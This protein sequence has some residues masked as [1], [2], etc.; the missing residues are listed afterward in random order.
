MSE[1][2]SER[3][4][5]RTGDG[6]AVVAHR[7]DATGP[8]AAVVI[9]PALGV[10]QDFYRDFAAWL[11]QRGFTALTFDYRGIGHSAPRSLRRF[12][13][14]IDDWIRFDFE[15]A[16]AHAR[17]RCDGL[18]L[19]VVGH[20]LGAQLVALTPSAHDV[21]ALVAVAGGSGYW[22]GF[23]AR[24]RVLMLLML[25]GAAPLSI[26]LAGY[27]PGR[28]LRILGD[29]PAG[30]MRQWRRW[31]L[32]E[33]YLVGVEPGAREAYARARFDVLSLTFADDAMMPLR[34]V[35]TLHAHLRG[36]QREA[37]RIT[38]VEAGGP[39]GHLGFFRGRHRDSLW[40][41]AAEWLG[42]RAGMPA[43]SRGNGIRGFVL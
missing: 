1:A 42:A 5:L 13:A 25:H 29:L 4:A 34:N 43:T 15:A 9:A 7:F 6:T 22:R 19:F 3:V 18:P 40:P 14:T 24:M 33:E 31:C 8:R 36:V 10:R 32:N 26:P 41:I 27:F 30:V 21:R 28:R 20:S 37:R 35:E 2:Q 23:P 17:E 38:P 39:V 16:L 12:R 11:A